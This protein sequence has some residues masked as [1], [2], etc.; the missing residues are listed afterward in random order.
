MKLHREYGFNLIELMIVVVIVGVLAAVAVPSYRSHVAKGSRAAAQTEL[1]QL[2]SLQERIYLNSSAYACNAITAAYNGSSTGGL[3]VST[4]TSKDGKYTLAVSSCA[5]ST[6]TL[7]AVPVATTNQVG[8]G[9]LAIQENGSK[10]WFQGNDN[11]IGTA[12][13]W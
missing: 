13:A 1:I 11:C 5:A 6:Y 3:G 9:C 4:G 8:N 12:T 10:Q 7:T 2:A